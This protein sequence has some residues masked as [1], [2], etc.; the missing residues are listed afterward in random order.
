[1]DEP[2][3][4]GF[5]YPGSKDRQI[6]I[7]QNLHNLIG[8]GSAAFYKDACRIINLNPPLESTTHVVA[9]LFREIESSLRDVLEPIAIKNGGIQAKKNKG[10]KDQHKADILSI[11]KSVE[12]SE[13][14]PIAQAWLKLAERSDNNLAKRAHRSALAAPRKLD[15]EFLESFNSMEDIFDF[16]LDR[17]RFRYLEY[18]ELLDRL[19]LKSNPVKEDIDLLLN[20]IPQNYI[21]MSY[22]FN[23]L[24]NPGWLVPLRD[25]GFFKRPPEL[26]LNDKDGTIYSHVWPESN[27]L[28][29]MA[30]HDPDEVVDIFIKDVPYVENVWVL[31]DLADAALD[32]SPTLASLLVDRIEYWAQAIY[33]LQIPDNL[34]L[35]II[36]IA[37]CGQIECALGLAKI[38][39]EI[40]PDP[41]IKNGSQ[42][43]NGYLMPD[44][45]TRFEIYDYGKLINDVFPKLIEL[46]GLKA[47]ELLCDI[48]NSALILSRSNTEKDNDFIYSFFGRP[49]IEGPVSYHG[50]LRDILTSI[51][52][53]CAEKI[54][55]KNE[56]E[57][58]ILI[59]G[60]NS[61]KS[62]I[63]HRIALHIMRKIPTAASH[64][65]VTV[66]TDKSLF[67]DLQTNHEY[68]L[69]FKDH[70]RSLNSEQKD[71]FLKWIEVGPDLK[72]KAKSMERTGGLP[73]N[74]EEL[75]TYRKA[76]QRDRLALVRN[77]LSPHWKDFYDNLVKE[78]GEPNSLEKYPFQAQARFESG[79]PK[80][81]A[82]FKS[83][84]VTEIA[85]FLKNWT[86]TNDFFGPSKG[87][88]GAILSDAISDEP[89]R[90]AISAMIFKELDIIYVRAFF[91]GLKKSIEK[92]NKFNWTIVLDLIKWI[93]ER[94][95]KNANNEPNYNCSDPN[96]RD[97]LR[98]IIEVL[99]LGFNSEN[100][101]IPFSLRM[102]VWPLLE[103]FSNDPDPTPERE[104][105]RNEEES[106]L[107]LFGLSSIRG[108][109]LAAII[110]YALWV[111]DCT[112]KLPEA[113]KMS[114][115][116]FDLMPEVREVL[117][118]HLDPS[119][120]PSL[121]IRAI[122]GIE[123]PR[124]EFLDS[125]W[126]SKNAKIIFP[127]E[128]SKLDL[129]NAA[130]RS[131]LQFNR[132]YSGVIEILEEQYSIAIDRLEMLEDNLKRDADPYKHPEYKIAEHIMYLYW[133]G[134]LNPDDNNGFLS[135]FWIKA[136]GDLRKYALHTI[137]FNLHHSDNPIPY[138][139]SN[140]LKLL[141]E[142]RIDAVMRRNADPSELEEFGWWFESDKFDKIWSMKQL[143][144]VLSL[145]GKVQLDFSVLKKL[146]E[147]ASQEPRATIKCLELMIKGKQ[148]K[149]QIHRW[150]DE[151]RSIIGTV[152]ESKDTSAVNAAKDLTNYLSSM[153]YL[154]Y[155][156][157]LK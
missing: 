63:F 17:V 116:G 101:R 87:D 143:I 114:H 65:I 155:K 129:W 68:T 38:L 112:E 137:G 105:K 77:T 133:W 81:K 154:E 115:Q 55:Q 13:K 121:A 151:I 34:S 60:L 98:N 146:A 148:N 32:M 24:K 80:S 106:E 150:R 113:S 2:N 104:N 85:D 9:H 102:S 56:A 39:F 96:F 120:D 74:E 149:W 131:Y 100:E 84:S 93:I 119:F 33:P 64:I 123:F 86:P 89:D 72:K 28:S 51:V 118:S 153:G 25:A 79:C 124:L 49:S 140:R 57:G 147:Y 141:W 108:Q 142:S 15:K 30:E 47:F 107:S 45:T 157:L 21:T 61:R 54:I 99:T 88:L 18:I 3:E 138:D 152:L 36:H 82:E 144:D 132:A 62:K 16:I 35:L 75:S 92:N 103:A 76:W 95:S 71:I 23:N 12:L 41:R 48:L 73:P 58:L 59:Q 134:K 94:S 29:R 127:T 139:V 67:G 111:R 109:A 6:K 97:I 122:Y 110:Q 44:P 70:F 66:L 156:D 135:K 27:Y 130:W 42:A 90:F 4:Q 43:G 52:R 10:N 20:N 117:R 11:L 128:E 31:Q 50:D 69:L 125:I 5:L 91:C 7:Y 78:I 8:Q 83:M 14:E 145:L 1:M 37:K 53:D 46:T 40:M 19:L 22:F 126:A 136:P 26:V